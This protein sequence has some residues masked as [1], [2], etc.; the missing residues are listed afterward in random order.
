VSATAPDYFE[1][2]PAWRVWRVV[3]RLSG[4]TL[5][6]F[7]SG[8]AWPAGAAFEDDDSR[9]G[10]VRLELLEWESLA[11]LP[12]GQRPAVVGR[13]LLWGAVVE[14]ELGWRAS[15]AYP[16]R[17]FLP[18]RTLRE[19]RRA[20]RI[21]KRLVPYGAPVSRLDVE[22]HAEVVP[23]LLA[24]YPH[25]DVFRPTRPLSGPPGRHTARP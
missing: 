2:I 14:T 12:S 8:R 9:I 15:R 13:V 16:Q 4:Y 5:A 23:A 3:R 20:E 1:P 22:A 24:V 17:L 7:P 21:A 18:A 11:Q 19:R 10:A 6:G 25:D